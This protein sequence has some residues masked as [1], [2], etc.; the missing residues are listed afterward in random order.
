MLSQITQIWFNETDYV[1]PHSDMNIMT[2]NGAKMTH[3]ILQ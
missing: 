2:E 1:P 3:K